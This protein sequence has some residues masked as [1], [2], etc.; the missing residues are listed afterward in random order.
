MVPIIG[1]G[2]WTMER[3]RRESIAA[4][5]RGLELGLTHIDTA[6]MYGG[7][8][9]EQIV[10]DAIRGRRDEVFLVSKVLPSNATYR[11]TVE[12]C[13]RSLRR[14]RTH[15][16]DVYLL[17]S[18]SYH[19]FED[20]VKGFRRLMDE[21]KIRAFGVSNFEGDVL[22]EAIAMGRPE[23]IA[24]NQVLYHLGSRWIEHGLI[25]H[26]LTFDVS[27]VGYSSFGQ[28]D[29]PA[30][31]PVLKEIAAAHN[32]TPH[33]V[34]LRFLLRLPGTFTIPKASSVAH[35]EENAGAAEVKLTPDEIAR[36]DAAFPLG[37]VE[38]GLPRL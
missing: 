30:D 25:D 7:G 28:G 19:P 9:V 1:Q 6:E 21:G 14:L 32:A 18:P 22:E 3:N 36:I 15:W 11:G 17:H 35:V 23:G 10:G 26:C 4:L 34:A 16:L 20:T 27:V 5:R 12:A 13:E 24:C 29:F 2:T 31:H 38:A 8:A 37:P 33:Q